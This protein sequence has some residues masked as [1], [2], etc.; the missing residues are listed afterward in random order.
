MLRTGA[1]ESCVSR[2]ELEGLSTLERC[3]A[4]LAPRENEG[5][6]TLVAPMPLKM[7]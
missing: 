4:L 7:P 6:P 3:E 2:S 5:A 1:I